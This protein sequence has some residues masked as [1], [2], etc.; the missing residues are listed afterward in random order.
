VK[1]PTLRLCAI[2]LAAVIGVSGA[3]IAGH[4]YAH[5]H[6]KDLLVVAVAHEW[7]WDFEYP[8]LGIRH[9]GELHLPVG[10]PIHLRLTTADAFH[11]FWLPGLKQA[12]AIAPDTTSELNLTLASAGHFYGNCD[13]G[14][15][16]AG[17][18]MKFAVFADEGA[19]FSRWAAAARLSKTALSTLAKNSPP[20]QCALN[21]PPQRSS[22]PA[23]KRLAALLEQ[24]AAMHD[25]QQLTTEMPANQAK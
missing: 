18:C 4:F 9:A 25:G 13:A 7:W 14:C 16:C 6:D 19:Q 8:S 24:R 3:A 23:A 10:V 22:D 11:S 2:T 1:I 20:P 17:V 15:G 5:R 21:G 12:I